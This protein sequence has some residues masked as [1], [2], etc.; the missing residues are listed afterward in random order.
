MSPHARRR[1]H[2]LTYA[3]LIL[4]LMFAVAGCASAGRDIEGRIAQHGLTVGQT[5]QSLQNATIDAQKQGIITP[6]QAIRAQEVYKQIGDH[7]SQLAQVLRVIDST[8]P[9][10]AGDVD[11]ARDLVN[12]IS[13]GVIAVSALVADG[14]AAEQIRSLVRQLL[15]T[16]NVILFELG[17]EQS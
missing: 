13:D 2:P 11:T 4:T 9:P 5:V 15:S 17:R 8:R 7:G 12:K 6:Q 10:A 3:L 14:P 1:L 16:T